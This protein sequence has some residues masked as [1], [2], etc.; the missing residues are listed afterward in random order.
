VTDAG[1]SGTPD[2]RDRSAWG[3]GRRRPP[4]R[5]VVDVADRLVLDASAAEAHERLLD[6][7]TVASCLPGVVPGSLERLDHGSFTVAV[8]QTVV[9]VA[10]N[11]RLLV[12][13][14][15]E[16]GAQRVRY[17]LSGEEPRLKMKLTGSADLALEVPADGAAA[18]VLL[19]Y[20]GHVE[21]EGRLAI[22]GAPIIRRLVGEMLERFIAALGSPT[23]S[24]TGPRGG[25]AAVARQES[26]M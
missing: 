4:P 26:T 1:R 23:A 9:G 7:D 15:A 8:K 13:L 10:A 19:D 16:E 12:S 14:T 25:A 3:R 18:Q 24:Q 11:W 2:R 6:M 5:S 17:G 22:A 21:V 20:S